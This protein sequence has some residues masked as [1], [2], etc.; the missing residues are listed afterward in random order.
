MKISM[1]KWKMATICSHLWPMNM[2]SQH[3]HRTTGSQ[4]TAFDQL[5]TAETIFC[6]N[7]S[8]LLMSQTIWLLLWHSIISET[9]LHL[10]CSKSISAIFWHE[11]LKSLTKKK[12][13]FLSLEMNWFLVQI[14]GRWLPRE[15]SPVI[16]SNLKFYN[17]A[18]LED[19]TICIWAKYVLFKLW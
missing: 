11:D 8:W 9:Y 3:L 19:W 15:P 4:R 12:S 2:T 14:W 16:R 1:N 17:H 10:N 13:R 18:V 6:I 5:V 7:P